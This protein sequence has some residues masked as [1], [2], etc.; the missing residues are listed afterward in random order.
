MKFRRVH[1]LAYIIGFFA[2]AVLHF[3][4]IK[5]QKID[6]SPSRNVDLNTVAM[7]PAT[8]ATPT[9]LASAAWSPE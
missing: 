5:H 7:A 4:S 2:G 9:F 1:V 3:H 8:E 6:P